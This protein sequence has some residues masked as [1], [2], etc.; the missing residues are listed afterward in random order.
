MLASM[1]NY[2][3]NQPDE[4]GTGVI[5]GPNWTVW[6]CWAPFGYTRATS[7]A[8]CLAFFHKLRIE[9]HGD[10]EE[11][12]LKE[13]TVQHRAAWEGGAVGISLGLGLTYI[14]VA[15]SRVST[16][17]LYSLLLLLFLY[18][19]FVSWDAKCRNWAT[20]CPTPTTLTATQAPT[21]MRQTKKGGFVNPLVTR[22]ST[23]YGEGPV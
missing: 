20:T 10:E 4:P 7:A 15:I 18:L 12:G 21:E 23:Y 3:A 14:A 9:E 13:A 6:F 5:L 17:F 2:N 11:G 22:P 1:H 8:G 16:E 19:C